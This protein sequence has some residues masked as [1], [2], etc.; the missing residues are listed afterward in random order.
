MK[1]VSAAFVIYKHEI[2]LFHRDNIPTISNPDKWGLIGGHAEGNETPEEALV[3]E[4]QEE[5][6][7]TPSNFIFIDQGIDYLGAQVT[8]FKVTLTDEETKQIKLGN[9]GQE[10]R[11]FNLDGFEKLAAEGKLSKDLSLYHQAKPKFIPLL[12][13]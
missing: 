8:V 13:D 11:F 2:L 3:R 6:N 1:R 4:C 12:L 9:E 5:I 7:V 10:V